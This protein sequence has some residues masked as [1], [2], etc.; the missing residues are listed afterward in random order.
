MSLLLV[1]YPR[2]PKLTIQITQ[3]IVWE[4]VDRVSHDAFEDIIKVNASL[5]I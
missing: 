2:F 3:E 5:R 4:I 1:R